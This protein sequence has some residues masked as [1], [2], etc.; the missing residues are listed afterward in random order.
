MNKA[1]AGVQAK[2]QAGVEAYKKEQD[3]RKINSVSEIIID[4]QE[5]KV[6][7]YCLHTG[8]LNVRYMKYILPVA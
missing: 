7:F 6:A 2:A 3:E 5:Q 4:P 1:V 8:L